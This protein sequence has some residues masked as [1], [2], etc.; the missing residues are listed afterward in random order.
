[1]IRARLLR[2]DHPPVEAEAA[3][4]SALSADDANILWIDL[5]APN[6]E[7]FAQVMRRLDI[8]ARAA[9]AARSVSIRPGVLTYEQHYLVTA[10][11]GAWTRRTA[12]W[13]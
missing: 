1:M 12:R 7:E 9:K 3:D 13:S 11:C 8:D 4:W 6:E 5:D 10:R 2:P